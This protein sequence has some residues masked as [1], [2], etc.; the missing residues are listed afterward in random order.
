MG[1]TRVE[2]IDLVRAI[3]I[4]TVLY[5]H[6][7]D[8]IF[9]ISSD[10]IMNYTIYSRIFNFIS[11]FIGRIGVPFFLMITGYLM[12]DRK[13]D[14][15]RVRKF[16]YKNCKGL[17]II[18]VIWSIIYA[19]S[20]QFITVKTSQVNVAEAGNL[21]FSHMWYMPMII[22]MYLSMPFV[23][24]AL[25]KFDTRTIYQATI[26]FALLAFL[27]PFITT[28]LSMHGIENVTIQYCLGF[29]GGVYGIYIIIGYLTKK[30]YFK[31]YSS[32]KLR[33]LAIVSF[34]ICVLFQYYAFIKGFDFFLWYEF[35]FI[36]T[37]SFA[38]FELCSRRGKIRAYPL[39]SFLAKY[40]F[41][42]FLVHNL[43]RLPLLPLVV[44]LP[45]SEP[46]KAI[47]LWIL[48][49]FFSYLATV[50]IYRI[51]RFGKYILYMR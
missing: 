27:L 30:D 15:E 7:T 41:A 5:I 12:L 8:G 39:V 28:L 3:A 37:G 45:Y 32:N 31:K 2:W 10:S 13:Y 23:S 21:F 35:P 17:I 6:A 18:T 34:L 40:S 4:L 48:L 25:E 11:L 46:V 9:I 33:L 16:W 47:I 26:V 20:L 22:G 38:L 36:L 1:K 24:A 51:P 19:V 42:V 43:F 50:I 29:S 44:Q 14:D 49:I